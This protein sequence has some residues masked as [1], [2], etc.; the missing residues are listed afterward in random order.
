MTLIE[1]S[2]NELSEEDVYKIA[3]TMSN[4]PKKSISQQPAS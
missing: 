2:N 3:Y 1:K 4:T